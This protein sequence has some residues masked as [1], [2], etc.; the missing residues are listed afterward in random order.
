MLLGGSQDTRLRLVAATE[1]DRARRLAAERARAAAAAAVTVSSTVFRGGVGRGDFAHPVPGSITSGFGM[2]FHPVLHV[3]KLHDGTDFGAGCGTPIRA[4][5]DGVVSAR[6]S[7]AGYGN[8]LM[9]DH[10]VVAG[11]RVVTGYNHATRYVVGV[12]ATVTRG[13]LIGYV[14]TTGYSTG[15]HLHLMVW[16]DGGL[17]NPMTWFRA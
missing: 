16:L 11:R 14:G 6:S 8:R 17:T 1:R 3:W 9:L 15:C 2:R 12:G 5:A 7:N 4:P 13:Q 10:G